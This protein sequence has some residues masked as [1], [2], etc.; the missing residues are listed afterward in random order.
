MPDQEQDEPLSAR[1]MDLWAHGERQDFYR[2]LV[3]EAF[4]MIARRVA[5]RRG[6]P[7]ED[8]QDCVGDALQTFHSKADNLNVENPFA[9]ITTSAMN[10]ACTLHRRRKREEDALIEAMWSQDPVD[11]ISPTWAVLAVEE[12]LVD[13]EA[14]PIWAV[15]VI[16]LAIEKLGPRQQQVIRYLARQ[17]FDFDRGDLA[18]LSR[19]AGADLGMKPATFRKTK[20][21]AYAR[22]R[23]EIPAA[24]QDLGVT[25]PIRFV[26]AFEDSPG[27]FMEEKEN[28]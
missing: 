6:I 16:E 9:Y 28:D 27:S 14:E 13:V 18:G 8:A 12:T 3:A 4:P 26:G 21:R 17:D 23:I 24:V 19:V 2:T 20:E 22:L 11:A 25:P 15:D 10:A 7:F 1:L 5:S